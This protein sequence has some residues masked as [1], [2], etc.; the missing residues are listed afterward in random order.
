MNRQQETAASKPHTQRI[1]PELLAPAGDYACFQ[2]ALKAG[3][4]AVYLGGAMYGARAY[5][6]NFQTEEILRALEEAHFYGKKIYLTVN[7]LMKQN[8]I[9]SLPSFIAPFYE[10][11]L[12][13]V[14]VQ[15]VGALSLLGK[16]F[17]GLPLHASTQ[18][19]V[20]DALGAEALKP[21]GIVR[22]VPA[23]ELSLEE[24][25]LLKQKS[26][27]E[28][29]CFIHGAMCYS[30]S[31][32]CLFSSMLGGRSGNRGR[33]AQPCRQ[34]YRIQ[35]AKDGKECYPLSL[36][37][38]STAWFLPELIHAGIDSF[39][40]EG[41]MK[42]P[43]YV[44][45]VTDIYRRIIDACCSG[46]AAQ[47]ASSER[48]RISNEDQKTLTTLYIRS[49]VSKGYYDKHNGKEM[50]TLHQP[51]YAG[52]D[53]ETLERIRERILSRQ[54]AVSISMKVRARIGEPLFLTVSDGVLEAAF[55]GMTVQPAQK[56][57]LLREELERQLAKTGGSGFTVSK[58][59]IDMQEEIFLPVKA[60]NELRRQCLEELRRQR[61]ENAM[62]FRPVPET[63]GAKAPASH[64]KS[65]APGGQ[66]ERNAASKAEEN[67][68]ALPALHTTV[69]TAEQL[70][71]AL[72]SRAARIYLPQACLNREMEAL[73]AQTDRSLEYRPEFFL[74]FPVIQ[75]EDAPGVME[76]MAR[77]LDKGCF[78]GVQLSSLSGLKWLEHYGW[79]GKTAFDH[80]IYIWNRQTWEFWKDRFDTWCAPLELNRREL[81][82]LPNA[83]KELLVY[84][85]IPMMVTA[86]CIRKTTGSCPKEQGSPAAGFSAKE[87]ALLDR[88][89]A[90]FPVTADCGSCLN[91][92]YNSVPL[93]LHDYLREIAEAHPAAVRMDFLLES[94]KETEQL[95]K[96]FQKGMAGEQAV[97]SFPFT[98]GHFKKGAQ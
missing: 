50:V 93:S 47:D 20:T 98:T 11:G 75:R 82:A 28:I 62:P 44:A 52:C 97:I 71:A 89:Q 31:G 60:V 56:C 2:A 68:A 9:D 70:L 69:S 36:K 23:R 39:K 35:G 81:Y 6:G 26:G 22:V 80:R 38:M 51:G 88:Y 40:I 85:R 95:L 83:K 7:T 57:P 25:R 72:H 45:G 42:K 59:E 13:G 92:I 78:D 12:D 5:A 43:E 74:S 96:L 61:V 4:D 73:V 46:S 77:L 17:P 1:K 29:E 63:D 19:T 53:E 21:L 79:K 64:Q 66:S 86:N 24:V 54:P 16:T 32:Q 84:G 14:I 76:R 94:G 33:C 48:P 90:R 27:L 41:R 18:M 91:I 37:D 55:S 10:A 3:A 87:M 49:G 34:P 15:D 58:I 67:N 65:S 30:Y 8:E